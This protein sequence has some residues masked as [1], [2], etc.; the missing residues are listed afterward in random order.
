[1]RSDQLLDAIGEIDDQ[2]I[3]EARRQ[4]KQKNR[5]VWAAV[6]CAAVAALA[7]IA[8]QRNRP[9]PA[10]EELLVLE[11]QLAGSGMGYEALML[12]DISESGDGNPWQADAQVERLPVYRNLAYTGIAGV[13][14]YWTEAQMED[15]AEEVAKALGE[16]ILSV[17]TETLDGDVYRL[18]AETSGTQIQVDG[19]GDVDIH[20]NEGVPLPDEYRF[21]DDATDQEAE[22]SMAYL[23]ERYADVTGFAD[24]VTD[25]WKDYTFAGTPNVAYEAYS[26]GK[27]LT[28]SILNYNFARVCF[29]GETNGTLK[30][31]RLENCLEAAELV[32][33]YPIITSDE[34]RELLLDGAY[35]TTVPESC[36]P[37]EKIS[38][39]MIAKTELIYRTGSDEEIY[40][41]YYR[42]YVLIR[43]DGAVLAEG[44]KTYGAYYVPAVSG[45]Y[46]SNFPVWDES[47][48]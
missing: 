31:I 45:E 37:E 15:R 20:F 6:A 21:T 30:Y 46:L 11:V 13:P 32:G 28:Q 39:A 41:P 38:D 2:M 36:L 44:L 23:L 1:M 14:A 4:K 34:A 42:F 22:Q 24:P 47:F 33:E 12:Y 19:N 48:N 10:S 17:E 16:T 27:D 29:S 3:L 5:G 40:M 8:W 7:V 18:S 35:L 26:R 43:E 9:V 25:I